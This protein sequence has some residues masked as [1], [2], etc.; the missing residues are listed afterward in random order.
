MTGEYI[1]LGIVQGLAEFFPISSSAHLV[2]LERIFGISENQLAISVVLHLGTITALI[3][4]FFKD[5]ISLSRDIKLLAMAGIVTVITGVIGVSGKGFFESLFSSAKIASLAL[6]VNAGILFLTGMSRRGKRDK[7]NFPDSVILG[8]TQGAAIVPGISRSGVT[9]STL[10]F[11]GIAAEAAFKFS[12]LVS[13]PAVL[14]AALLEAKDI[15]GLMKI[16][17]LNLG[18][19]FTCSLIAGLLALW[20]LKLVILKAKLHYFGFYCI[21]IAVLTL[22]FVK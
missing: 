22:L 4:F 19:G 1:I 11:R 6:I 18:I 10:F 13:I 15:S 21:I 2:I 12:F 14:G 8:F 5:I 20:A 16:N 17:Y 7:L 9:I 3:L